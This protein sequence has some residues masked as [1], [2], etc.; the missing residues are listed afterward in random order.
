MALA[1]LPGFARAMPGRTALHTPQRPPM[2]SAGERL[3]DG[4][5]QGR[6]GAILT[7]SNR[8]NEQADQFN[9]PERFKEPGWDYQWIRTSCMNKPDPAHVNANLENGWTPVQASQMPGA[10]MPSGHNGAIER[11]G[12]MLVERPLAMTEQAVQ[13]GI[14]AAHGQRHRQQATFK[15]VGA[16]LAEAGSAGSY[17]VSTAESDPRGYAKAGVRREI[18]GSPTSLYPARQYSGLDDD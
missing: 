18:V 3:P 9:V 11:D 16:V 12:L 17:E 6:N 2:R 4:T 8:S 7:R 1:P 10:F 15:D 5:F 13:D 14:R